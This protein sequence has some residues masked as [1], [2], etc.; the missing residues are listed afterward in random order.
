MGNIVIYVVL[1]IISLGLVFV[2]ISSHALILKEKGD[3]MVLKSDILEKK[4]NTDYQ[5][6]GVSAKGSKT[7]FVL[8]NNGAEQLDISLISVYIGP[9]ILNSSQFDVT[10]IP[11]YNLVNPQLWDGGELINVT[12]TYPFNHQINNTV[13]ISTENGRTKA[14]T[15]VTKKKKGKLYYAYWTGYG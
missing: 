2:L 5:V 13:M 3:S 7:T 6:M 8:K 11:K 10:L 1:F 14:I 9:N 15:F 4:V 12:V